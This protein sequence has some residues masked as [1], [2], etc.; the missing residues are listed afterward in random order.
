MDAYTSAGENHRMMPPRPP[1]TVAKL[2]DHFGQY[3]L[4]LK[5]ECGHA[6]T[7]QPQT[8]AGLAGWDA[9][10]EDVLKRLRCSRCGRRECSA[11]VRPETKR[12]G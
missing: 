9:L 8:L 1:L 3:V 5:C 11:T 7:A 6:R 10:L 12:D 4:N 2:S